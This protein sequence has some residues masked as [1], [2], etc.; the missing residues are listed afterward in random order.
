MGDSLSYLYTLLLVT[1]LSVKRIACNKTSHQFLSFSRLALG[2]L[3]NPR[4]SR[5]KPF[6]DGGWGI[7]PDP[8]LERLTG[9]HLQRSLIVPRLRQKSGY[10][11]GLLYKSHS[12]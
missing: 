11:P 6:L 3:D 5:F 9:A 12:N 4:A 10:N 7:P 8:S 1:N 2:V